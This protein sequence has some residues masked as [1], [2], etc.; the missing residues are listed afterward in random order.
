MGGRIRTYSYGERA[1][2]KK[3]ERGKLDLAVSLS[4][5]HAQ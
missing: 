5:Y 1:R 4:Y 3:E 2:E